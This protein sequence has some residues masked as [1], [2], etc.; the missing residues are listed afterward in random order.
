MVQLGTGSVSAAPSWATIQNTDLNFNVNAQSTNY[1]FL[2]SGTDQAITMSCSGGNRT[3]TL[4][5]ATSGNKGQWGMATKT[6][7]TNNTLTISPTS[8]NINGVS[9]V[10][11]D[12][13]GNTI[14]WY[15]DGS[16]Y[17]TF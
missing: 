4:P 8:C 5:Q 7:G 11:V 14:Q 16:N 12:T 10:L 2:T 6:D 3:L 13:Q 15:S 1:T 17:W 9:S